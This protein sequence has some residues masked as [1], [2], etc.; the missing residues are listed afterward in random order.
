MPQMVGADPDA[1]VALSS[2][3]TTAAERLDSIRTGVT[4]NL[5]ASPWKGGDADGFQNA[6]RGQLS[7]LLSQVEAML[8]EASKELKVN[9]DQQRQASADGSGGAAGGI[10]A[11]IGGAIGAGAGIFAGAF[12][13]GAFPVLPTLPFWSSVP[14]WL[15]SLG[16][17]MQKFEDPFGP[18]ASWFKPV[19][20]VVNKFPFIRNVVGSSAFGDVAGA[21]GKAG[22]VLGPIGAV[23]GVY[24]TVQS[25]SQFIHDLQDPSVDRVT[26]L[27]DGLDIVKNGAFASSIVTG[28]IGLVIGGGIQLGEWGYSL[29]PNW[30]DDAWRGAQ[31]L[32]GEVA[33]AG[34]WVWD[35]VQQGAQ[36]V[37]EIPGA[38]VDA[39]ASAGGDVLNAA[40]SA[41]SAVVND[42][43]SGASSAWHW[44]FG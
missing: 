31:F 6:W 41:G 5:A 39:A 22:K 21:L 8:R 36:V 9:A 40:A 25:G 18:N 32:G 15:S 3:M 2:Q 42:V 28:P 20:G 24:S 44:A 43:G 29:D 34:A 17:N 4:A 12:G 16:K 33:G 38:V 37:G 23:I 13:S 35:G 11:G 1:L 10:G 19:I 30:P 7:G 26:T 14:G 27:Q